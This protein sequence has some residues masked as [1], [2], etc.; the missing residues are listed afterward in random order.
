MSSQNP[1]D[2]DKINQRQSFRKPRF[3]EVEYKEFICKYCKEYFTPP[4]F[5]CRK[6]HKVCKKCCL[7]QEDFLRCPKCYAI[8][9]ISPENR[10]IK[11]LMN[12]YDFECIYKHRGCDSLKLNFY[13]THIKTCEFKSNLK[14][15]YSLFECLDSPC[16]WVGKQ[17]LIFDHLTES[18]NLHSLE[19]TTKEKNYII[20]FRFPNPEKS[21]MS[22][23]KI[24]VKVQEDQVQEFLLEFFYMS[25]F[26]RLFFLLRSK[27]L[28]TNLRYQIGVF[29]TKNM[30]NWK[31]FDKV[32]CDLNKN[33][34]TQV[35][36]L[37]AIYAASFRY[38]NVAEYKLDQDGKEI[39]LISFKLL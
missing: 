19:L 10:L 5:E 22:F 36:N 20:K 21:C 13:S 39:F 38:K 12:N 34:L 17:E 27:D 6:G 8:I 25:S 33:L 14:C 23:T 7:I 32:S 29:D 3:S 26:Q 31:S 15:Y 24:L 37:P 35:C 11:E 2:P 1:V 16:D 18:H 30:K 9:N 4:V 28:D